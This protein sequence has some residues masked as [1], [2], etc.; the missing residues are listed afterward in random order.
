MNKLLIA[1]ALLALVVALLVLAG[2][3]LGLA[4][5]QPDAPAQQLPAITH[6]VLLLSGNWFVRWDHTAGQLITLAGS[7]N[8]RQGD[9]GLFS[10][11]ADAVGRRAIL[12]RIIPL[13]PVPGVTSVWYGGLPRPRDDPETETVLLDLASRES[14][15]LAPGLS[16][17]DRREMTLSPDGQWIVWPETIDRETDIIVSPVSA[18]GRTMRIGH[19]AMLRMSRLPTGGFGRSLLW[20]PDGRVLA[21]SDDQQGVWL[22]GPNLAAR[23]VLTNVNPFELM[24]WSPSG[25]YLLATSMFFLARDL[26]MVVIDTFTGRIAHL[27]AP[28]YPHATWLDEGAGE[29]LFITYRDPRAESAPVAEL[30]RPAPG[31]PALLVRDA[32]FSLPVEP[33]DSAAGS[34][35]IAQSQLA[36]GRIGYVLAFPASAYVAVYRLYLFDPRSGHARQVNTMPSGASLTS[37]LADV[38]WAPDGSGALVSGMIGV[39][40]ALWYVPGDGSP[41]SDLAPWIPGSIEPWNEPRWLP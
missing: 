36:D 13:T 24:A 20:S 32:A 39:N 5:L 35:V 33:G 38:F 27:T 29:R 10:F 30:W 3:R 28:E 25:R 1:L 26:H 37:A 7:D 2:D 15:P 11:V 40:Q 31:G 19:A 14:A 34:A 8:P 6:D 22:G 12:L 41:A 23:Q 9:I 16:S 17:R 18:P 4:R 21:W